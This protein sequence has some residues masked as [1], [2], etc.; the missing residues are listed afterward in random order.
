MLT[1]SKIIPFLIISGLIHIALLFFISATKVKPIFLSS[2]IDVSFYSPAD[3]KTE[4]HST[5]APAPQVE[6]VVK[7]QKV[8][9]PSPKQEVKKE[10]VAKPAQTN[11]NE[12]KVKEKIEVKE[13]QVVAKPVKA[14]EKE[15][16]KPKPQS[17][18]KSQKQPAKQIAKTIETPKP[19]K[20]A[21]SA[22]KVDTVDNTA[23]P[24]KYSASGSQYDG[25]SFDMKDF[26]YAYYERTI[27]NKIGR[28]WEWAES[29]G[30]LRAVLYFRISRNGTVDPDSIKVA[31]SSKNKDFD[32][33]AKN[34]ILRASP[35]GDLPQAYKGTSIGVYFEFKYR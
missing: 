30:G 26:D 4:V 32:E 33:N 21:A 16:E 12:I 1:K 35:F 23:S 8:Q 6:K 25:V 27:V 34:A 11:K 5:Q 28:F 7:P 31:E 19:V 10:E 14:Q 17:S 24:T 22:S 2:P 9:E 15:K 29:F 3:E 13:K 18:D 20:P